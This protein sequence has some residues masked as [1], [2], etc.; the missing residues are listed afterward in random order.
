MFYVSKKGGVPSSGVDVLRIRLVQEPRGLKRSG[1]AGSE[2]L[3]L[4]GGAV[5][6]PREHPNLW[7]LQWQ[8]Q[9][10]L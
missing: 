4:R 3:G 6:A 1:D 8:S 10:I 7:L 2:N 9:V 5:D